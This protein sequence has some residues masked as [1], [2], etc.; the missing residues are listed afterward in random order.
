MRLHWKYFSVISCGI[1]VFPSNTPWPNTLQTMSYMG[2]ME[3]RTIEPYA[4]SEAEG[5]ELIDLRGSAYNLTIKSNGFHSKS[6]LN[7]TL[8][9][10]GDPF[11]IEYESNAFGNVEGGKLWNQMNVPSGSFPENVFR[12]LLKSHFDKGH[13]SKLT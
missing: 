12:L 9:I 7:K 3:L 6:N 8:E 11:E 4:F 2:N 13:K 5:I 1:E 10:Q